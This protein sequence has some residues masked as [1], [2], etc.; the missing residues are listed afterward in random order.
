MTKT[1]FHEQFVKA[2]N[3]AEQNRSIEELRKRIGISRSVYYRWKQGK[4]APILI[5]RH[6]A[7]HLLRGLVP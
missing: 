2:A 4:N 1:E 5:A 6:A 3:A 7:I